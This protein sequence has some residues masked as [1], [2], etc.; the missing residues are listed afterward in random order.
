MRGRRGKVHF[1]LISDQIK[2][3]RA[4]CHT[5]AAALTAAKRLLPTGVRRCGLVTCLHDGGGGGV[6]FRR[7][8]ADAPFSQLRRVYSERGL[9]R[10]LVVCS[11]V[12]LGTHRSACSVTS[13]RR[14]SPFPS[15]PGDD[16]FASRRILLV[17]LTRTRVQSYTETAPHRG[18]GVAFKYFLNCGKTRNS[19]KM[20]YLFLRPAHIS[21]HFWK[22]WANENNYI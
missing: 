1:C 10:R 16:A 3:G 15:L 6:H 22:E 7:T 2:E 9:P 11:G 14:G 17:M 8:H 12:G 21:L 18:I 20:Y 19:M 5:A 13:Q 4:L